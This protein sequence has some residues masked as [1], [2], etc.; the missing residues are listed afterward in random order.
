MTDQ[1]KA[2]L[3]RGRVEGRIVREYLE[4]LRSTKPKRGR[5]RTPDTV[6]SRLAAITDELADASPMDELMLIQERRDLEAELERMSN[7]I[8]I[9]ALENSFVE[10]AKSYADSK[11]ISYQSWRDVGIEASVLKRA[12][13]TRGN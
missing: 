5:K 9:K 2:A 13:I 3:A 6:N 1:H 4:G 12:G 7:V 8:D 10:V 11:K